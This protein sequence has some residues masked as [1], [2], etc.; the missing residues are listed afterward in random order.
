MMT[1]KNSAWDVFD[2]STFWPAWCTIC[3]FE[4]WVCRLF[5]SHSHWYSLGIPDFGCFRNQPAWNSL[6]CHG[7]LASASLG[8]WQYPLVSPGFEH[9]GCGRLV[10]FSHLAPLPWQPVWTSAS[11]H[12]LADRWSLAWHRRWYSQRKWELS[13]SAFHSSCCDWR[14]AKSKPKIICL[15]C[16]LVSS[17]L[18][19]AAYWIDSFTLYPA[20]FSRAHSEAEAD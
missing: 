16:C 6:G 10:L 9:N 15:W 2:S 19:W 3:S 5:N 13:C 18:F 12:W 11:S 8:M 1:R 17:A 14:A 20:G 4:R 7:S